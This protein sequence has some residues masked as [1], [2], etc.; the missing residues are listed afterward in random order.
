MKWVV[1]PTASN[2]IPEVSGR[3]VNLTVVIAAYNEA[4][5]IGPLTSRLI[6]TLD[7]M[8]ATR[9]RL[10]YVIEGEDGT[11][12]TARDFAASRPEITILYNAKPSGLGNAFK[13]GFAAVPKDTDIVVTMDADL[14]HQPEEIPR[15][16]RVMERC[17]VD[18]VIGSRKVSGSTVE[19]APVWKT[20]VS[21]VVNR[22]MRWLMRTGIHDQTSGFR[23]Y[24]YSAL[25]SLSFRNA[26]FA[27][28]PEMLLRARALGLKMRE[29]PI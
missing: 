25:Q 2:G 9:W 17:R 16:V 10:I 14:N 26:G 3:Q 29:E 21:D 13:R 4:A 28:L 6:A 22:C 15:L 11:L 7:R 20:R 5:N 1:V 23:A 27:F 18:I 8:N 12:E 19:H 24:R